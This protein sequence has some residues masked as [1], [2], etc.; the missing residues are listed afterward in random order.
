MVL[1]WRPGPILILGPS[2]LLKKIRQKRMNIKPN[3]LLIQEIIIDL[4]HLNAASA[5]I[6]DLLLRI[7]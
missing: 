1:D 3:I 4:E 7:Q 5:N 6:N 2:I